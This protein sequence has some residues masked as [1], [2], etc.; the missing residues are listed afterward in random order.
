MLEKP[1]AVF[2]MSSWYSR[3]ELT[4]RIAWFYSGSSIANMVG[5]LLAAGMLGNMDGAMG[6]AGWRWL[7]IIEGVITIALAITSGFFLPD[8]PSTTRWLNE[9]ERA[10][11]SWRLIDDIKASDERHSD[12]VW[13]GVRL[14]VKD[15]RLY[16][17]LLFQHLSLLSQTFQYF[18][19]SIVATLGF[20]KIETLLLTVPGK[21]TLPPITD[22]SIITNALTK[23]GSQ[24]SLSR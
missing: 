10:F 7:F 11:A 13:Q 14:A 6:I 1:G 18:F 15:Y 5:G 23:S 16:V 2:L 22:V 3:A 24:P 19:P 20:G 8:Y 21:Q 17:F 12:S 9:E 4:R